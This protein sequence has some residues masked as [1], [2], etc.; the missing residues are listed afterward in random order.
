MNNTIQNPQHRQSHA[1]FLV[2][3]A[4]QRF[5]MTL[6]MIQD[7]SVSNVPRVT[8]EVYYHVRSAFAIDAVCVS[9][10]CTGLKYQ[11]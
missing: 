9:F 5:E 6:E 3:E 1:I 10:T 7:V 4:A 11:Y 2:V 8:S